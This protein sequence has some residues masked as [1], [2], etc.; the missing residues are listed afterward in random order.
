MKKIYLLIVCLITLNDLAAQ[1]WL[2]LHSSNYAG[3]QGI[4]FQPASIVDSRYK[5]QMNIIGVSS[6]FSNNYYA[7]PAADFKKFD[8]ESDRFIRNTNGSDKGGYLSTDSYAPLSF[9]LTLSPKHAMAITLRMRAVS[10]FDG[11]S[12]ASADL[13]DKISEEDEFVID[14]NDSFDLSNMYVQTHAW[15]ELGLTYGRVV[16]DKGTKFLKVGGTVKLLTGFASGYTYI[17]DLRFSGLTDDRV[18]VANIDVETGF[19]DNISIEDEEFDYKPFQNLGLGL[20]LGVVYEYRPNIEKYRYEMDG[21]DSLI[22]RD[23]NKYKLK[24]GFSILDIGG[25]KYNRNNESGRI[26]GN[27]DDLDINELEGDIDEIF[28]E[29]FDFKRGGSYKMGLPTR[30]LG[31][32]DYH[33]AGGFYL[34]LTSQLALRGGASDKEKSRYISTLAL[35]PR[36]EGKTFGLALPV[37]YDKF[38]N[39]NSGI[40]LRIG[41]I[42]LG[43]RDV[44]SNFAF[45]KDP[46]SFDFHVAARFGLPYHK[47]RDKDKDGVSNRKDVCRKV[48]G[49]WEFKGCPD[50]DADGVQDSEDAC[51]DVPGL[52]ELQGCPDADADGI[53]DK[54]DLCPEVAG[55]AGFKGCPDTDGDGIQD[56]EDSCPD[57]A[58]TLEHQGCPDKDG[59]TVIDSEDLCPDLP[60]SVAKNGCP[61]SDGDGIFDN[62]DKCPELS[63]PTENLG[64]PYTDSD[65]DGVIDLNDECVLIPGVVENKGCPEIKEE[66]QEILNTAFTNLEFESGKAK[67]A[68]SSY[69]SMVEL[70]NLLKLKPDWKLHIVG[71]TDNV[72]NR[73]TNVRLSKERAQAVADFLIA[74]GL[75]EER[76]IVEGLGPDHPVADNATKEG[77]KANRRVELEVIFK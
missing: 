19:S 72:G 22:R 30:L 44:L 74:Q 57:V 45:G 52:I 21:K 59:D 47:K 62:E 73:T 24:V 8:F 37:S 32:L 33:V 5:F 3:V 34:N 68:L 70:A 26:T 66:E 53:I 69:T 13:L 50:R 17:S 46:K 2:G 63:G 18:E 28:E 27:L 20:D 16:F 14:P 61:D 39:L 76:F 64:C 29:Y 1:D 35:T 51:A 48:P 54:D 12:A 15:G 6:Y 71:H 38:A 10:N 49:V 42:V 58:G 75:G 7:I 9:M 41:N 65:G 4:S 43:S 40:S 77:R 67:I 23:K 25:I 55:L 56:S 36:I 31:E 60:G 11:F